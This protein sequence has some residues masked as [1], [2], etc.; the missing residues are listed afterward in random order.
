MKKGEIYE[1]T[2]ETVEFPNKGIVAAGGE[3]VTV[4]NVIPGQVVSF[5]LTKKR[6][7]GNQGT[8]I[9]VE[10]P[11]PL[12]KRKAFCKNFP[13]C[14]GCAYQSVDYRD[15][16][17]IKYDQVRKLL[18][19]V[20]ERFQKISHEEAEKIFCGI[21]ESPSEF[22]Y[23][24]KMEY[25]FGD[26]VKDGPLTLGLHKKGSTFDILQTDDC[27]LVDEDFNSVVKTVSEYAAENGIPYYHKMK[28]E[29][30]LRHLLVR[31]SLKGEMLIALVTTSAAAHDFIEL[32][33]QLKSLK[34]NG[35]IKGILHMKNDSV[36]DAVKSDETVVLSGEDHFYD[37]ILGL[38]FKITPFSFFQTNTA[39]AEVLYTVVKQFI[40]DIKDAVVFDLY[41]GTGTIAQ[42]ISPAA[43]KVIGVEIVEEAVI[44][45]VENAK[46]NALSNCEF[47][48]GDV[49][50]VLD[51]IEEKPD[52]LILDPPRD[53]INPKALQKI[54]RYRAQR[55]VYI[56][57]KPTSLARDLEAFLQAGYEVSKIKCV[58][59]FPQSVH[60]ETVV[61][62]TRG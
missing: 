20:I 15:Q 1:G 45:A 43:K 54:I 12:E 18:L 9:R 36:A 48:A 49:L 22:R 3:K 58:D 37:E 46:S 27:V 6:S 16:L 60:V 51:E 4:K 8:L 31:R 47:I 55:I 61:L 57:C 32:V 53:G 26:A 35:S 56:S 39:G 19:P 38:R 11:S 50:K 10:K 5:R 25:T 33:R 29:G 34:L 13:L 24:N 14:G 23:R 21:S 28:H 62:M 17:G 59:M 30:F 44:A 42:V 41:S 2:V 40:G 52:F 7:S